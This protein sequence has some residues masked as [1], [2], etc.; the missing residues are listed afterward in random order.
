MLLF[1][2][3]QGKYLLDNNRLEDNGSRGPFIIYQ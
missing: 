1:F 2:F 3:K